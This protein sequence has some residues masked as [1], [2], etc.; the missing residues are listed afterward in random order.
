[1]RATLQELLENAIAC[2]IEKP[3]RHLLANTPAVDDAP[4]GDAAATSDRLCKELE[5][6][7][8]RECFNIGQPG[9]L[10]ARGDDDRIWSW[11]VQATSF[12]LPPRDFRTALEAFL[13]KK[14]RGLLSVKIPAVP[15][16]PFS[17]E[18][19]TALVTFWRAFAKDPLIAPVGKAALRALTVA[20]SQTVVERQLSVLS[21]L[22]VDNRLH[23]DERY[24]RSL[25]M[26]C[27]N[28]PFF[29]EYADGRIRVLGPAFS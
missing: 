7:N 16:S 24:V 28:G 13:E 17:S 1:M 3:T 19:A 6:F 18:D 12:P 29:D 15:K 25:L 22:V 4:P 21:N 26:L 10:P 9:V 14:E 5:L 20:V 23:G 8:C 2:A 27:C 11:S